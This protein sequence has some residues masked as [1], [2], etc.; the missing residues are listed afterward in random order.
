M[1]DN[2]PPSLWSRLGVEARFR[3]LALVTA[4]IGGLA[5]VAIWF[6]SDEVKIDAI[7]FSRSRAQ[8]FQ[9]ERIGGKFAVMSARIGTWFDGLWIGRNLGVT[10]AVLTGAAVVLLLLIGRLASSGAET[11]RG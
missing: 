7:E 8:E 3:L 10:L 11:R 1:N 5:S 6:G 4:V 9:L 2:D